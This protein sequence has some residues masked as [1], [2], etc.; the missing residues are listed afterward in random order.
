MR[1]GL[2]SA[3]NVEFCI[4][5]FPVVSDDCVTTFRLGAIFM[6][7]GEAHDTGDCLLTIKWAH[8]AWGLGEF[9]P[10]RRLLASAVGAR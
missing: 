8:L 1:V 7:S 6:L 4:F 3:L 2:A 10:E 9:A 5:A